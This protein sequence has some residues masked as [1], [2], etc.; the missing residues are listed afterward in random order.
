M[1]IHHFTVEKLSNVTV[2]LT[3]SYLLHEALVIFRL[4]LQADY[5]WRENRLSHAL[6]NYG[7]L[8]ILARFLILVLFQ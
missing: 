7:T 3:A 6:L 5:G 4:L 1:I 2:L 8:I